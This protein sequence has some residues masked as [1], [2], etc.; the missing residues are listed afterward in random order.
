VPSLEPL[1]EDLI[2][3]DETRAENAAA[4]LGQMGGS[5]LPALGA[6][7]KSS[8]AD[9]RWWAV[10]TLAQMPDGNGDYFIGALQDVSAEV[11]QAAALA[12]AAH[13]ALQAAPVLVQALSNEDAMLQTLAANA[14]SAIGQP[15]VPILLDAFPGSRLSVKIHIMRVLAEVR[16]P[17]AI[18]VMM[19]A[20]ELDSAI[21]QH[22]CEIG[23]Q[24]LGL[25][26]VY[27]KMS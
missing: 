16:D 19:K 2:S 7:L 25:D 22:W 23:L 8:D 17:R 9:Q 11:R 1:L 12:L 24:Q 21:L 5:V 20:M 27:L 4:Q 10:R 26:M 13:P 15:V 6:L 3:G 18:P 14:L